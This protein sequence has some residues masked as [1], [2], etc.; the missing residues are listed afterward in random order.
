MVAEVCKEK[1]QSGKNIRGKRQG[2]CSNI[3]NIMITEDE[4]PPDCP[5]KDVLKDRPALSRRFEA[6]PLTEDCKEKVDIPC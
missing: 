3:G 5:E 4:N 1:P 2:N 6:E